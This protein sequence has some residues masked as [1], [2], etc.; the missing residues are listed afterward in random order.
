MARAPN[1]RYRSRPPLC[2]SQAQRRSCSRVLLVS[3]V[4]ADARCGVKRD[5]IEAGQG[6]Y[7]RIAQLPSKRKDR[8]RPAVF[9]L[10]NLSKQFAATL[11]GFPQCALCG[12]DRAAET[13]QKHKM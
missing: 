12:F 2:P 4:W 10:S 6:K 5:Q 9:S 3:S 1:G 8:L 13:G 7:W 11:Y